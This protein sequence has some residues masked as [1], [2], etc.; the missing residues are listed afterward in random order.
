M[1]MEKLIK[2]SAVAAAAALLLSPG[3][4]AAEGAYVGKVTNKAAAEECSAC[5][6]AYQPIFLTQRSWKAIMQNLSDHFGEDASLDEAVRK[7]IED[8]LVANAGDAQRPEKPGNSDQPP[9]MRITEL[10]WF[11]R[12]HGPRARAYAE[13]HTNIGTISNCIGCHGGAAN[14]FFEDD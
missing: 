9:V 13:G 10:R 1:K 3:G 14:G 4:A 7:E 2:S 8:Y 6:M 12:V 5:H 11:N